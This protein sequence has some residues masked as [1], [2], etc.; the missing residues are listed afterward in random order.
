MA[1]HFYLEFT[2]FPENE[3]ETFRKVFHLEKYVWAYF[4][5]KIMN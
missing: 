4:G 3:S 5:S 2:L 1:E